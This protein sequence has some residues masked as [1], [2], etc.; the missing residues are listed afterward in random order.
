MSIADLR[1]FFRRR[2]TEQQLD[3]IVR[4]TPRYLTPSMVCRTMIRL[5]LAQLEP[6]TIVGGCEE[7]NVVR[8]DLLRRHVEFD[9]GDLTRSLDDYAED[10][11]LP[12]ARALASLLRLSDA[13]QI[14]ELPL[15]PAGWAAC[16]HAFDGIS[17]RLIVTK[18]NTFRFDVLFRP[19][20]YE[21]KSLLARE[22]AHLPEYG[23]A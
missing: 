9:C 23:L 11:L 20:P 17:L 18:S 19:R 3:L 6:G 7:P 10:V 1:R 2:K 4:D 22:P 8:G 12:H 16:R 21:A 13:W 5:V 15:P 14:F